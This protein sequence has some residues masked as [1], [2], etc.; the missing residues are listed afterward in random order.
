M[1]SATAQNFNNSVIP[2]SKAAKIVGVSPSTL[3]R[4]EENGDIKAIRLLN[5]YRVFKLQDIHSLKSKLESKVFERKIPEPVKLMKIEEHNV[6]ANKLVEKL[7]TPTKIYDKFT[8]AGMYVKPA[9]ALTSLI[10]TGTWVFANVQNGNLKKNADILGRN[11]RQEM[12]QEIS[13][14]EGTNLADILGQRDRATD[15]QFQVNIP[16]A[17]KLFLAR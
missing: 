12:V 7:Q 14:I 9:L 3:R 17:E 5:G 11:A 16:S 13:S 4:L 2:V 6:S 1:N 8:K 10:L 15:F